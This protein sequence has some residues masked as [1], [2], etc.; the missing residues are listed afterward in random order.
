MSTF[1]AG[2]ILFPVE[3]NLA[4]GTEGGMEEVRWANKQGLISLVESAKK[5]IYTYTYSILCTG[6]RPFFSIDNY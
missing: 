3:K 2:S 6:K 1:T 4:A 5:K